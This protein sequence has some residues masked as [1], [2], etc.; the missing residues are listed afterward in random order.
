MKKNCILT[1]LLAA[2]LLNAISFTG[3]AGDTKETETTA[4]VDTVVETEGETALSDDLPERDF[5]GAD[6]RI[7]SYETVNCNGIHVVEESTGEG[8]NDATFK[9]NNAISERFNIVMSEILDSDLS[10]SGIQKTILAGDDAIELDLPNTNS[11]FSFLQKS[12]V[13]NYDMLPYVNLD[14][15]YWVSSMNKDVSIGG[16]YYYAFGGLDLS[17]LDY[18]HMMTFSKDMVTDYGLE[19]F[20]DLVKE[21]KWTLDKMEEAMSIVS[22]DP[23]VKKDEPTDIYGFV[24]TAKQILPNFWEAA[25]A[26]SI[27]KDADDT[28]YY[29][30]PGNE[31]FA[32]IVDHIFTLLWDT[33]YWKQTKDDSNVD[34]D[35]TSLME[36]GRMLFGDTTFHYVKTLRD[37]DA[38]F[39]LIPYPKW[40]D[41]QQ[42]Y[43]SRAEGG[44]RCP[45][46]PITVSDPEYVSIIME[47]LSF[48]G[49]T[50]LLP[51][52]FDEGLKGKVSRDEESA[53]ML[54]IIYDTRV[55]DLGDCIWV[56][57]IRDGFILTMFKNNKRDLASTVEKNRNKIETSLEEAMEVTKQ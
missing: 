35:M 43:M 26:K 32:T 48:A 41:T 34:P 39:G 6:F 53:A 46:V 1:I 25:G 11:A 9:I 19:N 49:Y 33:G 54:D 17:H 50:E 55:Y 12:C 5:G 31:N 52:Y 8:V 7:L 2:M 24:S 44:I 15:P 28:L 40:D 22:Y 47:A 21:G 3:C 27:D 13:L 29:A 38:D 10:L 51:A 45:M 14:K 36:E 16:Q 57:D 20:Y 4:P 18:T 56:S 23:D 30:I 42:E 37:I